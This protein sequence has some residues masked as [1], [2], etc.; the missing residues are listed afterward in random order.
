ML[1]LREVKIVA[2]KR[3]IAVAIPVREDEGTYELLTV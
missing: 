2:D 3:Y 1:S